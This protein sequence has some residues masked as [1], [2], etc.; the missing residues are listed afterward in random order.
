MATSTK[1][2]SRLRSDERR[3]QLLAAAGELIAARGVPAL[4]MEALAEWAGVSKGLGYWHFAN[5]DE[6]LVALIEHEVGA[7]S[8]AQRAATTALGSFDDRLRAWFRANL[9]SLAARGPVLRRLLEAAAGHPDLERP[10]LAYRSRTETLWQREI[11]VEFGLTAD[12][13]SLAAM[14]VYQLNDAAGRHFVVTRADPDR[15]ASVFTAM[16][17]AAISALGRHER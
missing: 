10:L 12:D 16:A 6:L 17:V 14:T 4:T 7:L 5:R 8:E 1:G 3:K 9:A 15:T 13:A 11:E 2:R